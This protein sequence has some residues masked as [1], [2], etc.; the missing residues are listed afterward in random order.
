MHPTTAVLAAAGLLCCVLTGCSV[1][2][3]GTN[4]PTVSRTALQED[5]ARRL[6]DAGEKPQSVTCKQD[7]VGEVGTTAHCEV[8]VSATNSFEPIVT[9]TGVDGSA[10]D[11]SMAPALSRQQ[12]EQVVA[13]LVSDSGVLDLKA[14]H[15]ESGMEGTV[16]AV[17]LCDVDAGGLRGRRA[18]RVSGVNGLMM[19]F[20]LVPQLMR[21]ETPGHNYER[22]S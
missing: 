18:V 16:G 19:S 6:A 8:V 11:Y 2:S 5:I 9:V 4:V 1:N 15:C 20:E 17:G 14:V 7:L 10:I 3:D 21:A 12:L 13:K 22:K